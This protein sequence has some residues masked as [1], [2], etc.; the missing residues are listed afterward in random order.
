MKQPSLQK[1]Q[2]GS[3]CQALAHLIGAGI[4]T[5][6]AL[7][8]LCQD[9]QDKVLKQVLT[10]MADLADE[11]WPLA[12]CFLEVKVFPSYVCTL[13]K[14]AEGVGKSEQTLHALADYYMAQDAMQRRIK[15]S[16]LYPAVLLGVL[17]VVL[18]V[19]LMW[20]LPVFNDVYA[21]LGSSLT[22]L[23]GVLLA[24][25]E[26]LRIALPWIGAVL[27]IA[28]V[29]AAVPPV[30]RKAAAF[31]TVR[32]GD[33]GA[34]AGVNSARFLQALTLAGSSGMADPEGADLAA[35]LAKDLPPFHARCIKCRDALD[36]GAALPKAL[37]D[38]GFLSAGDC[39]LLE[40]GRR[41]GHGQQVLEAITKQRMEDSQL[42]LETSLGKL[43]PTMVA[44]ACLMIG[45][46]LM[47]VMLPLM[48]IMN[49]IG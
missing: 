24:M 32:F 40:A 38:T 47:S 39:R 37:L 42:K 28:A 12:K 2:I 35:E 25:G 16:L 13:L 4:P 14:V 48:D 17:V 3:L 20:V 22:G 44:V 46:V 33:K 8:L 26:G 11:G 10:Q 21:Q 27:V 15:A 1:Q 18:F 36:G 34:F 43:E 31:F 9:E 23:A 29:L 5:G 45:V 6:D 49:A 19:L 41:S 7:T 30:R